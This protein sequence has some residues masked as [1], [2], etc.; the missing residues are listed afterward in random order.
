M[1]RDSLGDGEGPSHELQSHGT[2][3][4][5]IDHE[6][7]N[8]VYAGVR[9]VRSWKIDRWNSNLFTSSPGCRGLVQPD[10]CILSL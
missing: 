3:D 2:D 7:Q 5:P 9:F 8:R 6:A 1:T 4:S 10:L